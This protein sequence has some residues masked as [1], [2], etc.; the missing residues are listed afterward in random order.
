M[1][2]L[3]KVFLIGKVTKDLTLDHTASGMS[4]AD[5]KFELNRRFRD[6]SGE[7]VV[8]TCFISAKAFEKQAELCCRNLTKESAVFVEGVLGSNEWGMDG[9]ATLSSVGIK[10]ERIQ[11]L[12]KNNSNMEKVLVHAH[13]DMPSDLSD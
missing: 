4:V 8:D 3:K 1:E 11:F 9:Q 10:I 13:S 7:I 2:M 12:N 5:L 6:S